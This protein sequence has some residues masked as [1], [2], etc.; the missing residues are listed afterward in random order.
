[1]TLQPTEA[2]F[3]T[4]LFFVFR[5]YL[6]FSLFKQQSKC[7][8]SEHDY[9][10]SS[11]H[12]DACRDLFWKRVSASHTK[13]YKNPPS[14]KMNKR[15]YKM[16]G[17]VNRQAYLIL[18]WLCMT[19]LLNSYWQHWL[20]YE[21][22]RHNSDSDFCLTLAI[23]QHNSWNSFAKHMLADS[24]MLAKLWNGLSHSTQGHFIQWQNENWCDTIHETE[25]KFPFAVL[26]WYLKIYLQ[27]FG[28]L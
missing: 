12:S 10:S 5:I 24:Y 26:K 13:Q 17:L 9:S 14:Q 6:F 7:V 11:I 19:S 1:M 23:L 20:I 22:H 27:N 21:L 25:A 15:D 2:T 28:R 4:F 3:G 16:V 18:R 8:E